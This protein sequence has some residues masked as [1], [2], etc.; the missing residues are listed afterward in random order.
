[1]AALPFAQLAAV[2]GN[3]HHL[4]GRHGGCRSL[5]VKEAVHQPAGHG[6]DFIVGGYLIDGTGRVNTTRTND[7][8]VLSTEF[9]KAWNNAIANFKASWGL[10]VKEMWPSRSG[11]A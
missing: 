8:L 11:L 9:K 5:E 4:A 1:M 7:V 10:T 6:K 2:E 3:L